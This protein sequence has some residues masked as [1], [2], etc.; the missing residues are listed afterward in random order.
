MV[1]Q[2]AAKTSQR[3]MRGG[4]GHPGRR[5]PVRRRSDKKAGA[6]LLRQGLG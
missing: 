5:E 4:A 2:L 6:L 1:C 3:F